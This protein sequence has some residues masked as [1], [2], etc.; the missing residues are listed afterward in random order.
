MLCASLSRVIGPWR[1]AFSEN[2]HQASFRP[3]S[4]R[5]GFLCLVFGLV[6][7]VLCE[8]ECVVRVRWGV[9]PNHVW[10]LSDIFE[11]FSSTHSFHTCDS[12]ETTVGRRGGIFTAFMGGTQSHILCT[13][14]G[15]GV[16]GCLPCVD[17]DQVCTRACLTEKTRICIRIPDS[18]F[19]LCACAGPE[20]LRHQRLQAGSEMHLERHEWHFSERS[21]HH[22]PNLSQRRRRLYQLFEI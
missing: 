12:S 10:T 7:V 13:P 2:S 15:S 8:R 18:G 22:V 1:A 4:V 17:E 14:T 6:V 5:V 3:G 19:A 20:L 16:D 9:G 11:I 21:L